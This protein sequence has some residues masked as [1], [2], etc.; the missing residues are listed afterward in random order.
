[1]VPTNMA[2][3]SEHQDKWIGHDDEAVPLGRALAG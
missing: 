2:K 1:V 3:T